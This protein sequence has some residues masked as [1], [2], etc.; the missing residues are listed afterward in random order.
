MA[1]FLNQ[2]ATDKVSREELLARAER[3]V[4]VLAARSEACEQ[5]RR[6]PDET[7]RDYIDNGLLRICQPGRY[8]GYDLGYDVLCEVVQTLARGCGSQAWVYMV[9]ADNPLK[10]AAYDL[11]AQDDVWGEDS[12]RKLCV[13]VSAVGRATDVAGGVI[14]NG[15]HGFSS[16]IDHADWVM[17]GGHA[18]DE[19]GVRGR[20]MMVLMPTSAVTIIDDWHVVGL[21]GSGSKSFEVKDVFVPAHRI[22]D[23]AQNDAGQSPGMV[24]Y[25]APV[26]KLPRGGVSAVSYTAAVV[27]IAQGFLENF[28]KITAPR[29]SR[30]NSVAVQPGIQMSV[31]LASAE[32]EAA[33]RMYLGAIRETMAALAK[34]G[35]VSPEM[36]YQGKRNACYAAQ[37][38]LNAVQRLFNIAGGRALFENNVLQRQFRDCFAAAAHHSLV[39]ESAAIDYG[40]HALQVK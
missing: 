30:G 38:C 40:K 25:D 24:F 8:G 15:T 13:A 32:I 11:K 17:C 29:Q 12:T 16:G 28:L 14:W 26:M 21:A 37:L 10:L 39:W 27:G 22:L 6:A 7:V 33:E 9:L 18:Y 5:M 36:H 1:S 31:G 4:P 34:D 3:L 20:G 2:R 23:K 19:T 35:K